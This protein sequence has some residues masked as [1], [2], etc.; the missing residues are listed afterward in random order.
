MLINPTAGRGRGE[1]VFI[2]Q[3]QPMFKLAEIEFT[4][5][6]TGMRQVGYLYTDSFVIIGI[7]WQYIAIKE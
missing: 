6:V 1:S 7:S 2:K 5:I 4:V 3:V